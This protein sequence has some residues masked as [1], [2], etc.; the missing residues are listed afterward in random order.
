MTA[1]KI[2]PLAAL[3]S[4]VVKLRAAGRLIVF[5]NGCFDLLHVGHLQCLQF[6]KAQGDVLIV[7]INSDAS[8]KRLKGSSRP[9]VPQGERAMILAGLTCIDYVT[10]FDD[11]TPAA[12]VA[13]IIP[14]VLVKG[15]DWA[16]WVCGSEIVES[17]G[18]RVLLFPRFP[19]R[20]TSEIIGE[21]ASVA[22]QAPA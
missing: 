6:A 16:H 14:N 20:S 17:H 10:V 9:I 5:T 11:D 3:L 7:G 13:E 18:G 8:V 15:A 19:C 21:I 4:E 12:M 2:L 1:N 22:R